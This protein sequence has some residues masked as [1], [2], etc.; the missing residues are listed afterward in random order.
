MTQ[1][2]TANANRVYD[3]EAVVEVHRAAVEDTWVRLSDMEYDAIAGAVL[4]SH[5]EKVRNE[6][7]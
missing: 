5:R 4:R 6:N 2:E 3:L 7:S 1:Q